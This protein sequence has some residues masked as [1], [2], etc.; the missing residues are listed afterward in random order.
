MNS[1]PKT[2]LELDKLK[3]EIEKIELEKIKINLE[4]RELQ[5]GFLNKPQWWAFFTT[6]IVSLIT[7]LTLWLN[8]TFSHIKSKTES[9]FSLLKLEKKEFENK[10]D[11]LDTLIKR[12]TDSLFAINEKLI[13]QTSKV[14]F[15]EK[16]G[17]YLKQINDKLG[18]GIKQKDR[19]VSDLTD[20]VMKLRN[21]VQSIPSKRII[22]TERAFK[23][24]S[25]GS[26]GLGFNVKI[27]HATNSTIVVNIV[28]DEII[29]DVSVN[30]FNYHGRG[31]F[32]KD[33]KLGLRDIDFTIDIS[34]LQNDQYSLRIL[35][36]K[37]YRSIKQFYI[38]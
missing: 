10:K 4:N 5:K 23:I 32:T 2:K 37:K 24:V 7:L 9:E 3:G 12:K 14:N 30:V 1:E 11:I 15:L 17:A 36:N 35:I 20:T 18:F 16:N 13:S 8:G 21:F 19:I 28:G 26:T 29:E 38:L 31:V 22:I 33:V 25:D 6:A 27:S 34:R